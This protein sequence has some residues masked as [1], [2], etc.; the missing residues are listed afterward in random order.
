MADLLLLVC[1]VLLWVCYFPIG[2]LGQMWYLIVSIPDLCPLSY[3]N[4]A[5]DI[6]RIDSQLCHYTTL[7]IFSTNFVMFTDVEGIK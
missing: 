6:E 1:D 2:I 4:D 5:S 3:F 7:T